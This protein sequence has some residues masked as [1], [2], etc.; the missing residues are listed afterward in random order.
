[1]YDV[2]QEQLLKH[3]LGNAVNTLAKAEAALESGAVAGKSRSPDGPAQSKSSLTEEEK[4]ATETSNVAGNQN[5]KLLYCV[6]QVIFHRKYGY[7]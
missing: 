4:G 2:F 7:R 3:A 6:G 1:H 5:V